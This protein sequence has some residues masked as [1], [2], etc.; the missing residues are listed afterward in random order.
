MANEVLSVLLWAHLTASVAV[1][2]VLC[3]RLPVRRRFGPEIAYGLWA[4]PPVA[5]FGGLLPARTV[6]AIALHAVPHGLRLPATPLLLAWVAGSLASLV[7]ALTA[8][9]AFLR[10]ARRGAAGPAVV[11]VIAPKVVMP[12]DDGRF[13]AEER[14]VIRAHEREHIRRR[15]PHAGA[16]M[17]AF[18]CLAWFNPLVHLAVRL[19][20]IDQ[21]LACDAGVILRARVPRA[22]YARTLLKTQLAGRALPF[23]CYWPATGRHPLEVRVGLLKAGAPRP[24]ATGDAWLAGALVAVMMAA[25][26]LKPPEAAPR[27]VEPPQPPQ[28]SV[29]VVMIRLA[30]GESF[31]PTPPGWNDSR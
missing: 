17:T 19:A 24:T 6:E 18:Q 2:A 16:W 11:G 27:P 5:A 22:L 21:E 9:L 1:L 29:S 20:R 28:R 8:Q 10:Q 4:L 13:T 7:I 3:A 15:D 23:G 30:P 14:A 31:G 12:P 25:W 26:G